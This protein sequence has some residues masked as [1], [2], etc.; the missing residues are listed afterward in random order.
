MWGSTGAPSR[1]SASSP[2]KRKKGSRRLKRL[3]EDDD[4]SKVS[5]QDVDRLRRILEVLN[6]SRGP[7]DMAL[8]GFR[9]HPLKGELKD[10]G[11]SP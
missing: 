4:R 6:R 3:F 2:D 5:A 10:F 8:P 7:S 1:P 9:L 11:P